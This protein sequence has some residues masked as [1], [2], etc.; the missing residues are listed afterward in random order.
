MNIELQKT[1]QAQHGIFTAKQAVRCGYKTQHHSYHVKQKHWEKIGRGLY[2]LAEIPYTSES[3][4]VRWTLW[5]YN[6]NEQPQGIISHESALFYYEMI[7][8]NPQAV[9]LTVPKDFRKRNIPEEGVIIHK[10]NL[11]LSELDNHGAFMTTKLFRTLQ[12]TKEILES[13]KKW[14]KVAYKT[15]KSKRLT[16]HELEKLGIFT[17]ERKATNTSGS[18]AENGIYYE[19]GRH[20]EQDEIYYR[21]QDAKKI[22]D[23]MERQ[24][25]WTMNTSTYRKRNSQERGFTLVELLVVIAIISILAGM[26]LPALESAID[27][28]KTI[29]CN[30]NLK[31]IG[32]SWFIYAGDNNGLIAQRQVFGTIQI[33]WSDALMEEQETPSNIF[34]CPASNT[35]TYDKWRTYSMYRVFN[36]AT[37]PSFVI[38]RDSAKQQFFRVDKYIQPS[39]LVIAADSVCL[40][41]SELRQFYYFNR[42]YL[43]ENAG[44]HLIHSGMANCILGDGHVEGMREFDLAESALPISYCIT[45][46]YLSIET[47]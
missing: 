7:D 34:Y 13:Q 14:D 33:T 6:K 32:T 44:I 17:T 41:D 28:S 11:P 27:S 36:E 3:K 39:R 21:A 8:E 25:R 15:I 22:F 37:P 10:E 42:F 5:S 47:N 18:N 40:D 35:T 38:L 23:S 1:A 43:Q 45:E 19:I 4:F 26:L 30:N 29:S 16:K 31:Q 12:D 20:I 24:G 9:H 2:R 46:D